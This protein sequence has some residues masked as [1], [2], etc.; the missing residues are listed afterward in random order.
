MIILAKTMTRDE[1]AS[2]SSPFFNLLLPTTKDSL[3]L[4]VC[5]ESWDSV[6][7]LPQKTQSCG[8]CFLILKTL[9]RTFDF[10]SFSIRDSKLIHDEVSLFDKKP[11]FQSFVTIQL[12][13]TLNE[14]FET[15]S[16]FD[17]NT[18][19]FQMNSKSMPEAFDIALTHFTVGSSGEIWIPFMLTKNTILHS[20]LQKNLNLDYITDEKVICFHVKLLNIELPPTKV[21]DNER[22]FYSDIYSPQDPT[23]N[24]VVSL[25]SLAKVDTDFLTQVQY[26][27]KQPY[28]KAFWTTQQIEDT[29]DINGNKLSTIICPYCDK[30]V[31]S[32][33]VHN[34]RNLIDGCFTCTTDFNLYPSLD[35]LGEKMN[36]QKQ[37]H[38]LFNDCYFSKIA[39]WKYDSSY[40]LKWT[41]YQLFSSL[42]NHDLFLQANT[43]PLVVLG[44]ESTIWST[45]LPHHSYI[46]MCRLSKRLTQLTSHDPLWNN[47]LHC[48]IQPFK[49]YFSNSVFNPPDVCN[50]IVR[51]I[52]NAPVLS[53]EFQALSILHPNTFL[54]SVV[55]LPSTISLWPSICSNN[56][57]SIFDILNKKIQDAVYFNK[58]KVENTFSAKTCIGYKWNSE[59]RTVTI[60]TENKQPTTL[61]D[62]S[63]FLL[64]KSLISIFCDMKDRQFTIESNWSGNPIINNMKDEMGHS[65]LTE[66]QLIINS[67]LKTFSMSISIDPSNSLHKEKNELVFV[68]SMRNSFA[69]SDHFI[70]SGVFIQGLRQ[71][72]YVFENLVNFKTTYSSLLSYLTQFLNRWPGYLYFRDAM[73]A[74]GYIETL[75]SDLLEHLK[76]SFV[77]PVANNLLTI[78]YWANKK[79]K[80]NVCF[81]LCAPLAAVLI[82]KCLTCKIAR[83]LSS[84]NICQNVEKTIKEHVT[85]LL[86]VTRTS[87]MSD[88]REQ[89]FSFWSLCFAFDQQQYI[90]NVKKT[91]RHVLQWASKCFQN[92]IFTYLLQKTEEVQF[93]GLSYSA[94][95]NLCLPR[96]CFFHSLFSTNTSIKAVSRPKI[97]EEVLEQF[98]F[99]ILN[100]GPLDESLRSRLTLW[101]ESVSSEIIHIP[102]ADGLH[103]Y[104]S[105]LQCIKSHNLLHPSLL[106]TFY[107]FL[108]MFAFQYV[109]SFDPW[110]GFFTNS[111]IISATQREKKDTKLS[112]CNQIPSM[113]QWFETTTW[114]EPLLVTLN[115]IILSQ[116]DDNYNDTKMFFPGNIKAMLYTTNALFML[117]TYGDHKNFSR[118]LHEAFSITLKMPPFSMFSCFCLIALEYLKGWG[119]EETP[120]T[121]MWA[122]YFRYTRR[123]WPLTPF[124]IGLPDCCPA[125]LI[126]SQLQETWSV[127][128]SRP[129]ATAAIYQ[130]FKLK[131]TEDAMT[132]T[133]T[134]LPTES[135]TISHNVLKDDPDTKKKEQAITSD[136]AIHLMWNISSTSP[137]FFLWFYSCV[138]SPCLVFL[139]LQSDFNSLHI[140]P[141]LRDDYVTFLN[142]NSKTSLRKHS[143]SPSQV[144]SKIS[145]NCIE[146]KK[147]NVNLFLTKNLPSASCYMLGNNSVA[148]SLGVGYPRHLMHEETLYEI[149]PELREENCISKLSGIDV[150]CAGNPIPMYFTPKASSIVSG[151]YHTVLLTEKT[152]EIYTWGCNQYGQ[153]GVPSASNDNKS[154]RWSTDLH[155]KKITMDYLKFDVVSIVLKQKISSW[156]NNPF[157]FFMNSKEYHL[158]YEH[159]KKP[160]MDAIESAGEKDQYNH[161]N[162]L[163]TAIMQPVRVNMVSNKPNDPFVDVYAGATY[164]IART[165][166]GHL[167]LWGSTGDGCLSR[168]SNQL[169]SPLEGSKLAKKFLTICKKKICDKDQQAITKYI[170]SRLH[171]VRKVAAG[172]FHVAA[173]DCYGGL[174]LWGQSEAGQLGFGLTSPNNFSLNSPLLHSQAV[175]LPRRLRVFILNFNLFSQMDFKQGQT[176]QFFSETVYTRLRQ[177]IAEFLT[178]IKIDGNHWKT[179]PPSLISCRL[180]PR[181][182]CLLF[183]L[184]DQFLLDFSELNVSHIL[185]PSPLITEELQFKLVSCG[186]AHTISVGVTYYGQNEVQWLLS[187]GQSKYG[188]LGIDFDLGN[189]HQQPNIDIAACFNF[190]SLSD[191]VISENHVRAT[192]C[193]VNRKNDLNASFN[194][195]IMT[196]ASG[197]CCNAII[198][199]TNMIAVWGLNDFGA[200]CFNEQ[201]F[202]EIRTPKIVHI[203]EPDFGIVTDVVFAMGNSL[204]FFLSKKGKVKS[205]GKDNAGSS[206]SRIKHTGIIR[207]LIDCM[208]MQHFNSKSLQLPLNFPVCRISAGIAHTVFLPM[209]KKRFLSQ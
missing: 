156:M 38:N 98:F 102:T 137:D 26:F 181:F 105:T 128:K 190:R 22:N 75:C 35:V 116:D 18:F 61:V 91:F 204:T 45:V 99:S 152:H 46:G 21:L 41:Q 199:D 205:F 53:Q 51:K 52:S 63:I 134:I 167:W 126:P 23:S 142:C 73:I 165:A 169:P 195:S 101:S 64:F 132:P 7:P 74:H 160:K 19:R 72:L 140:S 124:H 57:L 162:R 11:V 44:L 58:Q 182:D 115:A 159:T 84:V 138:I 113:A 109:L 54:G 125:S 201:R 150:W 154:Y 29:T 83:F 25:H 24:Y 97:S 136:L 197:G 8:S 198:L 178:L 114:F 80:K 71:Q 176:L 112:A 89:I 76:H 62:D 42:T 15:E 171:R 1:V 36:L 121:Q 146:F 186:E 96:K 122:S 10:S 70:P 158:F 79:K 110:L 161:S 164:S 55:A 188:Q 157:S 120:K 111:D 65:L 2:V 88:H 208:D 103:V 16:F 47:V 130:H 207:S 100:Y 92:D 77:S 174:W 131:E 59:K 49:L 90:R 123:T 170:I 9:H 209:Q 133:K 144:V 31:Y 40:K 129:N 106:D 67:F 143:L 203:F 60:F 172:M 192:P 155:P 104:W 68:P 30:D 93:N 141:F 168:E 82:I 200:L 118:C 32:A 6:I 87:S 94:A 179:L 3:S 13:Y 180:I 149:A 81:L 14:A 153:C 69:N 194:G 108:T 119:Q 139:E 56:T 173:L 39:M 184:T 187:W 189:E 48:F 85:I 50:T 127:T 206:G 78:I 185:S 177:K 37:F 166:S 148:G 175:F 117:Y 191:A 17:M 27:M 95:L 43:S 86:K 135:T 5:L 193:I 4:L 12:K 163:D 20:I 147:K 34:V 151:N 202:P 66:P 33:V 28:S 107:I 145:S 196:C 183:S